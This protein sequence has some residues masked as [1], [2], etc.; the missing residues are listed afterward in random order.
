VVF[1]PLPGR[2]RR[3]WQ[4]SQFR[5][6]L[7]YSIPQICLEPRLWP[8]YAKSY[9]IGRDLLPPLVWESPSASL[10]NEALPS[11]TYNTNGLLLSKFKM[12]EGKEQNKE[13]PAV[14]TSAL[15][16]TKT[17]R[18]EWPPKR[19]GKPATKKQSV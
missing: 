4:P 17:T 11:T 5:F 14:P 1:G 3:V 7:L 6:R 9:A 8:N 19:R 18:V 16:S 12:T 15:M 13:R 10:R 2:G